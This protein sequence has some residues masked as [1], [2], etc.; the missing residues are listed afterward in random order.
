MAFLPYKEPVKPPRK[1]IKHERIVNVDG[2]NIDIIMRSL[3]NM[4]DI[5]GSEYT[6]VA[7]E[8]KIFITSYEPEDDISYNKR[9][10][11]WYDSLENA[12]KRRNDKIEKLKQERYAMYEE[13]K[14]E[15]EHE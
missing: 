10:R 14:R 12:E 13:L 15:F 4:K 6:M 11:E 9:L 2:F 1:Q 8:G 3:G 5:V 7:R